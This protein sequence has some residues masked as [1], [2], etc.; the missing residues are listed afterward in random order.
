ML[1]RL[2]FALSFFVSATYA[3]A[4]DSFTA[5]LSAANSN[6]W[7]FVAGKWQ[8][9]DGVL[10][11]SDPQDLN[12][13]IFAGPAFEDFSLTS[14]FNIRET[15]KGVRAAAVI[16]RA[17]GTKTYYWL[18]LDSKNGSA[19]L[20]RSSAE[21][22][23]VEILRRPVSITR[24]A[25]HTLKVECK[26]Q[27]ISVSIDDKAVL[28]AKDSTLNAGR[29]GFGTSEGVVAYRN[30]KVE[31]A[32]VAN[33]APLQTDKFAYQIISKGEL[34]GPYQA[35]PDACRLP[36][37]DILA[38]FYA[39]YGHISLPNQE[40]PRGGRICMTRSS[41]EG[42][43]W[44]TPAVLFDGPLD[45]RD[46]HVGVT[47]DGTV[48]CSFFTYKSA[49]GKME[50]DTC[51]VAS[52]DGGVTWETEPRIL[53][54]NWAV[55]APVRE[56]SDGTLLLGVYTEANKTAFGGVLR[57]ENQGKTWSL[58][59]PIDPQSGVRLD[60]ETDVIQ[61]KD[62]AVFAA[63]RGD[64]KIN[65][66]YSLSRDGGLTWS[67]VKD[68]GFL[69]HCPHLT[70]LSS[71][72]ILLTHRLPNTALHV[73]RD[74]GKTWEGP[75]LIDGV[76]GAYAST[77]ELKDKSVLVVYYEEGGGSRI[78][79]SRFQLEPAGIKKLPWDLPEK[80]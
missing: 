62:G 48:H 26:G 40:W 3:M 61:L 60:A 51:L 52:K 4:A 22:A 76:I 50:Y 33:A 28:Q 46:P 19:I 10:E 12:A 7:K 39:G 13:A 15:N 41:D 32:Q 5:D 56:L 55:S 64:G 66:H 54:P 34:A 72:E 14:E 29:I 43:T 69:G 75:I 73:S 30:V 77:V 18:H 11:Q 38:V 58:P 8:I 59:I 1:I 57:S 74:D 42:A 68:M 45:D 23:W 36:N 20:T 9:L 2:L 67:P 79:A 70:R 53:A 35:F 31:G 44:T 78:R 6:Q 80:K 71:G 65:M 16:F 25:W 17:T 47:T 21:N 27:E 49:G 37:G 63:L 24:D